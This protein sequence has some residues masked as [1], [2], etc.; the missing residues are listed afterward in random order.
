MPQSCGKMKRPPAA[1]RRDIQ[2]WLSFLVVAH[3]ANNVSAIH[4]ATR[5]VWALEQELLFIRYGRTDVC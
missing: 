2:A 1:V 3:E 4:H 5:E